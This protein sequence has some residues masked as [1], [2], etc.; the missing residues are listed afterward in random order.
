MSTEDPAQ[1]NTPERKPASQTPEETESFQP[2]PTKTHTME[3][4]H[5][6]GPHHGKKQW[7]EYF[8]EFMMIF[9]AVTLGFLAENL[10]EHI[11]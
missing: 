8:L 1:G 2:D 5:H 9:L 7:R 4:H 10:R 11:K 6:P 3:V